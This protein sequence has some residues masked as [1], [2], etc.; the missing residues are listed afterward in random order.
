MSQEISLVGV[1][2]VCGRCSISRPTLYRLLKAGKFPAPV[3][4]GGVRS[5]RWRSDVVTAWIDRESAAT[6][7]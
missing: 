2:A 3:Y 4:P 7:A 6:A 5:P 1:G